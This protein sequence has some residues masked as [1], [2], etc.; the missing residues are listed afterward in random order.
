M[1][2]KTQQYIR[3][4]D[5]LIRKIDG[6]DDDEIKSSLIQLLCIRVSGLLEVFLKTRISEYSKGKVPKEINH[7]L[8]AKFKDITNLKTSKLQ[9]VLTAFSPE[10]AERF[11]EYID[12]NE[13]KKTSLDS[14]I[15]QRHHI[16]HGHPSNLGATMMYQY[17]DD[18][19]QIVC[20]LDGVIR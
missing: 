8:T 11:T 1:D 9:D 19:K 7:F 14:I 17:Y 15:A 5:N 12:D 3:D 6:V 13:Q 16:A 20:F 2:L 18:I 10:W 4:L